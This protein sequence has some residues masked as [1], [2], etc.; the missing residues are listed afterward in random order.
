VFEQIGPGVLDAGV[1]RSGQGVTADESRIVLGGEHRTLGRT[2]VGHDAVLRRAGQRGPHH[3]GENSHRHGH[4]HGLGV[5]DGFGH[6]GG[7][8][9]H[10][11]AL[12]RALERLGGAVIAGQVGLE[13][14]AGGQ[15][16][17][18]A[19]QPD[20]DDRYPHA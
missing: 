16:H 9:V 20:P 18:A 19:D 12:Q 3:L 14:L 10:G 8:L 2:H 1:L 11:P 4:E 15:A 13:T 6:A 17:G 7:G 5:A